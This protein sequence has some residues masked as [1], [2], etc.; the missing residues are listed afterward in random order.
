[1]TYPD[2]L[3]VYAKTHSYDFIMEID[4]G[5]VGDGEI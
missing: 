1:M 2:D 3:K 4:I 5:T